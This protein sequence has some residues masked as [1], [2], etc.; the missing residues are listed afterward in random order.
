MCVDSLR[1]PEPARMAH[2]QLESWCGRVTPVESPEPE[3]GAGVRA[4]RKATEMLGF[5][6]H[7]V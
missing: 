3:P 6:L 1:V 2:I 5:A 4:G 7:A